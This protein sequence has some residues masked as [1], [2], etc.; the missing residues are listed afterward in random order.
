MVT[1]EDRNMIC[2]FIRVMGDIN[3]WSSWKI[4]KKDI[5]KEY[6]ELIVALD[7]LIIAKRTL[8]TIIDK[9]GSEI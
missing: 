8:D 1:D 3:R 4:R 2:Y 7:N 9:I 6:P 5:A